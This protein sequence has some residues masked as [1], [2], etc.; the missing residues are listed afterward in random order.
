MPK[1][2]GPATGTRKKLANH[3]RERG[4]SPPQRAIARYEVGELV[5]LALDPSV[6]EGRFHH[7]F[8]GLTGT[9][10]GT[11]G[12]AYTVR[13]TDGGKEKTVVARAAHLKS[14][15]PSE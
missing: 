1:S 7:R 4:I 6:P 11:Q 12:A 13:I 9:V 14:A 8:N 10:T 3:P 2:H 5:H 15:G